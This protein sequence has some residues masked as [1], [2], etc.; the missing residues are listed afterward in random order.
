VLKN[1]KFKDTSVQVR[2]IYRIPRV[3]IKWAL[4]PTTQNLKNLYFNIER[5]ESETGMAQINPTPIPASA[6]HEFMDYTPHLKDLTKNYYYRINAVEMGCN[7]Q[8]VQTF[9]SPLISFEDPPDLVATYILEEHLY[10]H[11]FVYGVP[12][13]IYTKKTEGERCCC[14]D[15]VIKRVTKS[16]CEMCKGVGFIGGY[17]PPISAWMEFSRSPNQVMII[18]S[19]E[20]QVQK[21]DIT[22]TDYPELMI[23]DIIL[24]CRPLNF[25][26]VENTRTTVKNQ[27]L[28]LQMSTV[29]MVNRADIEHSIEIPHDKV[30]RLLAELHQREITPEF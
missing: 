18:D 10:V 14:W 3:L 5:G 16:N 30:D 17:Y 28:L 1:I 13:L 26:R 12:V 25:W 8:P 29:N 6:R 27:T 15:S 19:G 4:E 2:S 24:Q 20:K 21:T 23:G 22:F 9:P 7:M 11:Q